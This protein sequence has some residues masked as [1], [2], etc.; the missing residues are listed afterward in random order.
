MAA[1]KSLEKQ[2]AESPV[3]SLDITELNL[4]NSP[5]TQLIDAAHLE[6]L[7][8]AA[9]NLPPIVVHRPTLRV[10]DGVHRVHAMRLV[11]ATTIRA[12]LFDGNEADV[13]LL[14]VRLNIA[15]G[16]PLS[17]AE[18]RRAA[19]RLLRSR[20]AW[21]DRAVAK[22]VG[23]SPKTVGA[24]RKACSTEEI[25]HSNTRMGRDGRARPV[26]ASLG[27]QRAV[28]LLADRPDASVRQIAREA[29]ISIGTAHD[30]RS[31]QAAGAARAL[32]AA[33]R[34]PMLTAVST[35]QQA[36][37]LQM[38]RDPGLRYSDH[39]RRLLQWLTAHRLD[40]EDQ[41][42]LLSAVPPHW[43]D[44]VAEFAQHNAAQWAELARDVRLQQGADGAANTSAPGA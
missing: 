39:G 5:R 2:L 13:F 43:A 21:S 41:R 11:G 25:P 3:T 27:R 38:F 17:L 40:A 24:L 9:D 33:A 44:A 7:V 26:D 14:A 31:A 19:E 34:R 22:V 4:E 37:Y 15:H 1:V 10:I 20:P 29:G 8:E 28:R 23:L 6:S 32:P 42:R 16:L 30:V 12:H 36:K 18:R 35:R